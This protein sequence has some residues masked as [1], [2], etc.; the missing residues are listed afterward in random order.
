MSVGVLKVK[1][2]LSGVNSLKEKRSILQPFI[3]KIRNNYNISINELDGGEDP[4]TTTLGFAHIAK[5]SELNYKKLSR[6]V[7]EAEKEKNLRIQ[8]QTTEV[9]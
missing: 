1:F 3:H 6:L 7:E 9:I 5:S 8:D 2:V 4:A